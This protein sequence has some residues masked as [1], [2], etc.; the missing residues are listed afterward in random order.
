MKRRHLVL[1]LSVLTVVGAKVAYLA[2]AA[3]FRW[4]TVASV[5]DEVAFAVAVVGLAALTARFASGWARRLADGATVGVSVLVALVYGLILV[6]QSVL[7]SFPRLQQLQGLTWKTVGPSIIPILQQ[8]R[9]TLALGVGGAALLGWGFT[10]LR[11]PALAVPVP[12]AVGLTLVVGVL[13][14]GSSRLAGRRVPVKERLLLARA[15]LPDVEAAPVNAQELAQE[16]TFFRDHDAL[17]KA[18][19]GPAAL[20][21]DLVEGRRGGDILFVSLESVRALDLAPWGGPEHLPFLESLLPHAV[22]LDRLYAQ[23]VRSTKTFAAFDLGVYELPSWESYAH[24]LTTHFQKESLA[25]QLER[26]GYQTAVMVNGDPSYDENAAFHRARGYGDVLYQPDIN[27]GS[28]NSDDEQMIARADEF[29]GRQAGHPVFLYTW[30]FATHHPYGREY[31]ADMAGWRTRHPEGIEHRGPED[32]AR[33]L[34][35]LRETD[36]YLRRLWGL[37]EKHGRAQ[38]ATLVV[39]GDHG[40][41]FGEHDPHNV[42]HGNNL[43]EE[44]VRVAAL[45]YSPRL[46]P[47]VDRRLF[48]TKD[49]AASLL[50][51]GGGPPVLGA[52]RS[53]FRDWVHPM[54]VYLFNSFTRVAGVIADGWKYR[55]PLDRPQETY[56]ASLEEIAQPRGRT[57]EDHWR[58]P[59]GG[60]A[61]PT[62]GLADG[63]G[64]AHQTPAGRGAAA[65]GGL[66]HR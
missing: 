11:V 8:Q 1:L 61:S 15:L 7:G 9:A 40:E 21:G 13:E 34:A 42:F 60:T 27:P 41:A 45:V 19:R 26:Q 10:K 5:L 23:D 4:A 48:M 3:P 39:V 22:V 56:L 24:G 55:F 59:G 35:A 20:Y 12:V 62:R 30:P 49:V 17:L 6:G 58:C 63:H 64:D 54:P 46:E 38:R 18:E 50:E 29:L 2:M 52:G 31:W 47:G 36:D 33:Y 44:S 43:Y 66:G 28:A 14:L 16:A 25:V 65:V 32:K 53:F 37:M 57:A 51:L